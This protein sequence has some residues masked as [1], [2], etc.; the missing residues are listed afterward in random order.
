MREQLRKSQDLLK[1]Q[2]QKK[3]KGW[4]EQDRKRMERMRHEMK[5]DWLEI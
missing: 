1:Q 5:G 3:D 2:W 4:V